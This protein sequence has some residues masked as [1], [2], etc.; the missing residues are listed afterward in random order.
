MVKDFS[1][2]ILSVLLALPVMTHADEFDAIRA[3]LAEIL[4]GQTPDSIT[5]S[6]I[7][8]VYEVIYDADVVYLTKDG[9][10]MLQGDIIDLRQ[11]SNVTESKRAQARLK[12]LSEVNEDTMIVF[13]PKEAKHTL[14][15]FTDI[16]CSYCRKLHSEITALNS[17]GIKVRY[18]ALP[19]A[20]LDSPSYDKA[21]TVWCSKDRNQAMTSAKLDENLEKKTCDNPVKQ[22]M[23]LA[24]RLNVS[25][26]PTMMLEDG[27]VIPGFLPVDKLIKLLDENKNKA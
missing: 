27:Q 7:P 15:V 24:K 4:P 6:S 22:H 14:T 5:L 23:A 1:F 20:G 26:T 12:A 2:L 25:G 21:V 3:A 9:R 18:L 10:Y 13:G 16:D 19:R 8:G 11:H 17:H